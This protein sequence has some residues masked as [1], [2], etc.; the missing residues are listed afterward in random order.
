M[1]NI[2]IIKLK[3]ESVRVFE[4]KL[5]ISSLNNNNKLSGQGKYNAVSILVGIY[6]LISCIFLYVHANLLPTYGIL[7]FLIIM[8]YIYHIFFVSPKSDIEIKDIVR[9]YISRRRNSLIIKFRDNGHFKYRGVNLPGNIREKETV[10][11]I[12]YVNNIIDEKFTSHIINLRDGVLYNRRNVISYIDFKSKVNEFAPTGIVADFALIIESVLFLVST[13]LFLLISD[14]VCLFILGLC[15]ILLIVMI[16]HHIKVVRQRSFSVDK[17]KIVNIS[18]DDNNDFKLILKYYS[19]KR[20][21]QREFLLPE[22]LPERNN[23]LDL[24]RKENILT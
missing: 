21:I 20:I 6:I 10:L 1:E 14:T 12:L 24:L 4:N 23:T 11:Q 8:S 18:V 2:Q 16:I 13:V 15:A 19:F 17:S 7:L 3:Y 9:I 22:S 5:V